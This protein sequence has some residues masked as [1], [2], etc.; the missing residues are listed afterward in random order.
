M[1][2]QRTRKR[3]RRESEVMANPT[4]YISF[5]VMTEATTPAIQTTSPQ[6]LKGTR[7]DLAH[8]TPE[9]V[10]RRELFTWRSAERDVSQLGES[11]K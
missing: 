1:Q 10:D 11:D 3:I 8:D 7:K 4:T 6:D 5:F 9:C 2:D